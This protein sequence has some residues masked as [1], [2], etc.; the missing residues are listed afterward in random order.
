MSLHITELN[1]K[2]VTSHTKQLAVKANTHSG[3]SYCCSIRAQHFHM[4]SITKKN[5]LVVRTN[6]K[7]DYT[8]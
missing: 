8:F 3:T 7:V 5:L 4:L 6:L 1:A 2:Y